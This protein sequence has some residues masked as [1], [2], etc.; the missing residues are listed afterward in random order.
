MCQAPE[1]FAILVHLPSAWHKLE[2]EQNGDK[3]LTCCNLTL[4]RPNGSE[5]VRC[6][7]NIRSSGCKYLDWLIV[8][9]GQYVTMCRTGHCPVLPSPLSPLPSASMTLPMYDYSPHIMKLS[10]LV[11]FVCFCNKD[12]VCITEINFKMC[13]IMSNSCK[14]NY[15]VAKNSQN[16]FDNFTI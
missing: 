13:P 12:F 9:Q 8:T 15:Y 1:R 16:N 7:Y 3:Y 14:V 5:L 2:R 11:Y 4:W 10:K 6:C